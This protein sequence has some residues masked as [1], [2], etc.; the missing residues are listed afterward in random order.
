MIIIETLPNLS[1][2]RFEGRQW[3]EIQREA[4]IE[5]VQTLPQQGYPKA[6]KRGWVAITEFYENH[7]MHIRSQTG[8]HP[9]ST[10]AVARKRKPQ[11]DSAQKEKRR[12]QQLGSTSL[13]EQIEFYHSSETR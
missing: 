13:R 2:N 5:F 7:E 1:N 3:T 10:F 12:C 9:V 8:E 11:S 6:L 4:I